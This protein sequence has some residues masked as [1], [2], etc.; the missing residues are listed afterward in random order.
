M[1]YKV[2]LWTN[3][4]GG[5]NPDGQ[6]LAMFYTKTQALLCADQWRQI[7]PAHSAA[8]WDGDTWTA[9]NPIP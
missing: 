1:K 8:V 9:Y 7:G 6:S 3:L 4:T 5:G 2:I